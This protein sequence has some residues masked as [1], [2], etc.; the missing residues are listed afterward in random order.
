[1]IFFSR[2][3]QSLRHAGRG[4]R[5]IAQH[6]QSFRIQVFCG[7][8][9]LVAMIFLNLPTWENVLLLL[10]VA[11]ILVLEVINSIFE[12]ITDAL[13][14]RLSPVVREVK[15]MMAGAVLIASC[16]AALIALLLFLPLI[17]AFISSL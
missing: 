2:F 15:D 7:I 1:M 13:K 16:T 10:L 5:E 6:E 11:S 4:L 17:R 9:V 12:R 3:F 8:A 14:P